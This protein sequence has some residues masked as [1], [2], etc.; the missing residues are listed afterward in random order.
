MIKIKTLNGM[1]Y[2]IF[3]EYNTN[4]RIIDLKIAIESLYSIP[5]K[6]FFFFYKKRRLE[7][8]EEIPNNVILKNNFIVLVPENI[9]LLNKFFIQQFKTLEKVEFYEFLNIPLKSKGSF[10]IKYYKNLPNNDQYSKID[11]LRSS[12]RK[13]TLLEKDNNLNL[14]Q[15]FFIYD[16]TDEYYS[17]DFF[18]DE[19]IF[20]F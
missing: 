17:E 20:Y 12:L 8:H 4:S 18:I 15:S 3:N 11:I 16:E 13:E 14:N 5:E 9:N 1:E 6:S 2:N 10:L 19:D 7:D